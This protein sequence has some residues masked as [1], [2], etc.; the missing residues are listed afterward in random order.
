MMKFLSP[1]E[2]ESDSA[3]VFSHQAKLLLAEAVKCTVKDV[4]D[5]LHHH[6]ICKTDRTWY[7]RRIVLGRHLPTSYEE[8]EHLS[9]QRPI[10]REASRLFPETESLEAAKLKEMRDAIHYRRPP[11]VPLLSFTCDAAP[12]HGRGSDVLLAG[13]INGALASI[14]SV[15]YIS[16]PMCWGLKAT[17]PRFC[18]ISEAVP[19]PTGTP[20]ISGCSRSRFSCARV[21]IIG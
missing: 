14:P 20:S 1:R 2:K 19:I 21:G 4:N 7:F 18:K 16:A 6:D 10:A 12:K 5:M 8:R 17:R 15:V 9:Y 3:S 13:K 11:C